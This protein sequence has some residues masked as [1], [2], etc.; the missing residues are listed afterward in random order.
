MATAKPHTIVSPSRMPLID[1]RT[2]KKGHTNYSSIVRV[3]VG[4]KDDQK[5]FLIHEQLLTTRSL[6]F[7]K[8]MSGAWSES[9]KRTVE[10]PE[11]EAATFQRY[12]D[13]LYTD[14]VPIDHKADVQNVGRSVKEE[15]ECIAK[16]YIL[17]E[18]LQDIDTKNKAVAALIASITEKRAD[19]AAYS[20]DC[21]TLTTIYAGTPSNSLMRRVVVD[22]YSSNARGSWVGYDESVPD[23]FVRDLLINVLDRRAA[24]PN[25]FDTRDI[26]L[27]M[28]TKSLQDFNK[29]RTSQGVDQDMIGGHNSR[30]T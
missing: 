12:V 9:R 19:G 10:L 25:L 18:K 28:E 23:E 13:L 30:R 5:V 22:D 4:E 1:P 17:A 8:A 6:F 16:L 29:Q 2:F 15:Q 27:Y 24:G 14:Q 3:R 20:V 21:N 11:D 7:K 26:S